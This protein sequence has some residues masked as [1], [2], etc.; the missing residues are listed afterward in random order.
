[1]KLVI[2]TQ[3]VENYG[4]HDWDGKGECPQYWKFKGG[5]TYV[6]RNIT[7]DQAEKILKNGIPHLSKLIEFKNE[8]FQEYI[9]GWD[10]LDDCEEE[11]EHWVTPW[12]LEYNS[13]EGWVA[14]K[15]T[16]RSEYWEQNVK[17]KFESYIMLPEGKQGEY[18][19]TYF[20][21]NGKQFNL[22][23]GAL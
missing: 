9:L 1:M 17:S 7:P 8:Y 6:V 18:D 21:N 13:R 16:P 12:D 2:T 15:D 4:A 10:L 11:C 3:H 5:E 22:N 23:T 19:C 20:Y 14:H